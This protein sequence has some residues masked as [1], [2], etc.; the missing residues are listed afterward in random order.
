ML[1]RLLT[2][3]DRGRNA[4][5]ALAELPWSPSLESLRL[6]RSFLEKPGLTEP[7]ASAAVSIA[8][9][10]DMNDRKQTTVAIDALQKVVEVSKNA[11]VSLGPTT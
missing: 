2:L 11:K 8:Q 6:A 10:L 1:K 7:A 4:S 3:D 5:A 9:K